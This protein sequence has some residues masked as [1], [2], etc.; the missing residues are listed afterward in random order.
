MLQ[1]YVYAYLREDGTP[2]YIGKGK[3]NRILAKHTVS[4]PADHSRIVF[5]EKNL[6]DVGAL[7]L[8]RRYIRWYG[9]KD[10]GTGILRNMTDGGESSTGRIVKEASRTKSSISNKETWNKESTIEKHAESMSRVWNDTSR[11]EKI[12]KSVSGERNAR[13]GK[14]ALNRGK[15]HTEETR[16]KIRAALA[17]RRAAEAALSVSD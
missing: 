10:L 11:N 4:P 6:S 3:G 12:A 9:R 15:P 14:P 16:A 5:L 7:A 8:E 1:F 17:K 2:Y 13:F